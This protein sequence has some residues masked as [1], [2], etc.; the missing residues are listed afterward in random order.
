MLHTTRLESDAPSGV[1]R[2]SS[3]GPWGTELAVAGS[4]LAVR[5]DSLPDS[6]CA[7]AVSRSVDRIVWQQ[8]DTSTGGGAE[9]FAI[10]R[11]R[12]RRLRIGT[13]AALGL[14]ERGVP[15]VVRTEEGP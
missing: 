5:I 4:D 7:D 1:A 3:T 8:I 9:I 2:I 12:P 14:L 11:R 10:A 6:G 13:S 15:T